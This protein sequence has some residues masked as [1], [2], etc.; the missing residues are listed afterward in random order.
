MKINLRFLG[1]ILVCVFA[2][3]VV[4][5]FLRRDQDEDEP[6][7]V[8]AVLVSLNPASGSTIPINAVITLTFDNPPHGVTVSA[9]IV[10]VVGKNVT[11]AGPF[12][13]GPLN[14]TI[15]WADGRRVVTYTVPDIDTEPPKVTGSTIKDGDTLID[16]EAINTHAK[17]EITFSEAV[18]GNIILQ[19]QAGDDV[20]WLGKVEGNKAILELVKGK[21]LRYKT[22]YVIAGKV[23]DT[24][25]NEINLKISFLTRPARVID[26]EPPK[27]T[28]STIKDGEI[29]VDPEVI[30][31]S[32]KIEITFS[33]AVKGNITLQTQ[34]GDDVGWLGKVEGNK[35]ML[36][37]A[38]GKGLGYEITYV[39]AGRILDTAGNE[40]NLKIS[41][42]TRPIPDTDPPEPLTI[43]LPGRGPIGYDVVEI[44]DTGKIELIFSEAVEGA[45]ALLT[46]AGDDVGWLGRVEGNKAI[47]EL[48]K[49]KELSP[50][51]TYVIT[52]RVSDAAG[53]ESRKLLQFITTGGVPQ[54]L[55]RMVLIPAG[56]FQMGSD[57]LAAERDESP[58]HT[59]YVDAF[60]IDAYE[61][62]NAQY[63]EF[64]L[65]N[66]L[67]QKDPID[68]KLNIGN[69]LNDWRGNNY[70]VGKADH[71][72]T[73][74]SW[75][76][77]MAYAEWAGKRL[78]TEAEWEKAARGGLH[79]QKYPWRSINVDKGFDA[80]RANYGNRI[81]GTTSVGDYLPNDYGLYD[82]AGNVA[83]WC[84]DQ[85][86]PNF[87][88][89]SSRN[90]PISGGPLA[91]IVNNFMNVRGLRVL[92]GGS[93][94]DPADD[95]RVAF[96]SWAAPSHAST[97][98]GFRCAKDVNR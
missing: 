55:S 92:R 53:N 91:N 24:A 41:F 59:V 36:E 16:P 75:Y 21:E 34:A 5:C 31:T 96:R 54:L 1:I 33:E 77:A 79:G 15:T 47:L 97:Y 45:I 76:A 3:S 10:N 28:S 80:S 89:V 39:V 42:L 52:W 72:V 13:P 71:P 23:L 35:A 62:T 29:D 70:P 68:R 50:G 93:W 26:T 38:K 69:Y 22:T 95:T 90:N 30:N 67:W 11:I 44:N 63:R 4:G 14:L 57:A 65:A 60:Y 98:I 82:V 81:G 56:E 83:E 27:V 66:P 86:D 17:I 73:H 43:L 19:T 87:Y 25:G 48:V 2:F 58:V 46:Q 85:W 51:S 40:I 61:V 7:D 78:P 74:V 88:V 49:G 8:T 6:E 64:I 37:L 9:G 32:A 94:F 18:K 84:L 12:T 20:G